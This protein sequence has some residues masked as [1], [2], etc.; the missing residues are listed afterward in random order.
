MVD[1]SPPPTADVMT[2]KSPSGAPTLEQSARQLG[3]NLE[4]IDKS[5][6]VVP[7]DPEKGT[8]AVM[9]HGPHPKSEPGEP[10]RGPWSNPKIEPYGPVQNRDK[11]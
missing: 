5:F 10:Y 6:G 2:I 9:V 7:I 1:A 11:K 3:V 4:A 8:Y